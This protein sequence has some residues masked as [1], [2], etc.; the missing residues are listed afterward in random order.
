MDRAEKYGFSLKH[1]PMDVI[2]AEMQRAWLTAQGLKEFSTV[3][4]TKFPFEIGTT[5]TVRLR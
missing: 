4:P 5:S 2:V 1:R 3:P